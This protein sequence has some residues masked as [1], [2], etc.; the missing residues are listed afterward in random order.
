MAKTQRRRSYR[1]PATLEA[2]RRAGYARV[3]EDTRDLA[4]NS[5]TRFLS[6]AQPGR[7]EER[8][9][10]PERARPTGPKASPRSGL[11]AKC[12]SAGLR[13]IAGFRSIDATS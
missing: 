10:A 11:R 8:R 4:V 12:A 2:V 7:P 9:R 13:E 6:G 1:K 3:G 5:R